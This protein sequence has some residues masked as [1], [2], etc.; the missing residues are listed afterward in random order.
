MPLLVGVAMG[1]SES[2]SICCEL[3]ILNPREGARLIALST[4]LTSALP[5]ISRVCGLQA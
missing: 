4:N 1:T 2:N 3:L 5:L